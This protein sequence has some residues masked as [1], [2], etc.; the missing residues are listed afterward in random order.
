[1]IL[2]AI[3]LDLLNRSDDVNRSSFPALMDGETVVRVR[4]AVD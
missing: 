4:E 1:V 2:E 3:L